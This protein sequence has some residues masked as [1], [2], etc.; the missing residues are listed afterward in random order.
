MM[1][2]AVQAEP[3]RAGCGGADAA[4]GADGVL[5][6]QGPETKKPPC[7]G[8]FKSGADTENRTRDLT[9]TKGALY[10]LSH[11]SRS[12]INGGADGNRTRDLLRDRQAF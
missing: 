6:L 2:W 5:L 1:G 3:A 9:L 8:Q 7:G 12:K 10:Q 4:A 11:I